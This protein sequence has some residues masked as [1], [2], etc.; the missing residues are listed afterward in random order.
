MGFLKETLKAI[1]RWLYGINY[2][3]NGKANTQRQTRSSETVCLKIS[4]VQKFERPYWQHN[5]RRNGDDFVGKYVTRY[6]SWQGYIRKEYEGAYRFHIIN[7]P[8]ALMNHKHWHCFNKKGKG[9]Y[10]A[11]FQKEPKDVSTGIIVIERL[12]REAF[13]EYG[14]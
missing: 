6:G 10:E 13:E 4:Q 9:L 3:E 14:G 2:P 7:P 11:H 12:I 1:D 5:W 8:S